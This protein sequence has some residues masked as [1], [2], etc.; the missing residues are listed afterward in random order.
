MAQ[1]ASNADLIVNCTPLGMRHSQTEGETP[2][3]FDIIPEGVLVYDLVY[4]PSDT[5]LL[6]EAKRAGARTLGGLSMLIYQGAESFKLWTGREPPLEVMF[7]EARKAL[8]TGV[9]SVRG[10]SPG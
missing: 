8:A 6:R 7:T 5:P 2:I 3:T 4:N 1:A 9:N 10:N